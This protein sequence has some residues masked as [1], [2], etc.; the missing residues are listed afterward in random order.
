MKL[1]WTLLLIAI[2]AVLV[3]AVVQQV[4]YS[5][6]QRAFDSQVRTFLPLSK[7]DWDG[8]GV[9]TLAGG[10]K[11]SRDRWGHWWLRSPVEWPAKPA[12]V[13]RMNG[14][15]A[16]LSV[17]SA[18]A[19]SELGRVGQGLR[20]YGLD[21][22]RAVLEV[23]S[24]NKSLMYKVGNTTPL[25]NKVY[26][27]SADEKE[28]WVV[29]AGINEYLAYTP[30]QLRQEGFFP[31]NIIELEALDV[32]QNGA[33]TRFER[34]Q[35][36]NLWQLK[37]GERF[38]ELK[39]GLWETWLQNLSKVSTSSTIKTDEAQQ[40][41]RTPAARLN[42]QMLYGRRSLVVGDVS[43][44]QR[45]AR[46]EGT[47]ETFYIPADILAAL[48][49]PE[50]FLEP[51]PLP[52][53]PGE[54]VSFDWTSGGNTLSLR[55]LERGQ[56][57]V[58]SQNNAPADA[59]AVS[60]LLESLCSIEAKPVIKTA[61]GAPTG[62]ETIRVQ[63]AK[64]TVELALTR[65]AGKVEATS[66]DGR[67]AYETPAWPTPP[68]AAEMLDKN[69]F[70]ENPGEPTGLVWKPTGDA[71]ETDLAADT[72]QTQAMAALIKN[73]LRVKRWLP[74][75]EAPA[76][77]ATQQLEITSAKGTQTLSLWK[78]NSGW[79]AQN[80]QKKFFEPDDALKIFLDTLLNL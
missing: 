15:L 22:P 34:K 38:L 30:A 9:S 4:I 74:E 69:I 63:T 55:K 53:I 5:P 70:E 7:T 2:N 13:S 52:L 21:S 27:L 79:V 16:T 35:G 59:E 1:R 3:W 10:W 23:M 71:K 18:F 78:T 43:G 37:I 29:D 42:F 68:A 19:V 48:Q 44:S 8:M 77:P 26:V 40:A 66:A 47:Q 39:P 73:T 46:W 61:T 51:R 25:G 17:D 31:F 60:A 14:Y 41:L 65:S 50:R 76:G 45:S 80:A 75:S 67:L 64:Q 11:V 28:V 54:V 36:T 49:Q 56:W 12:I 62:G 57:V 6:G 33:T 58:A 32:E 20:S 24:G 72:P